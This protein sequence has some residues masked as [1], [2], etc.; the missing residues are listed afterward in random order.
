MSPFPTPPGSSPSCYSP[1]LH[2]LFLKMKNEQKTQGQKSKIN[3]QPA[4]E[5]VK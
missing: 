4:N 5:P 2:V 1:K 3:Q